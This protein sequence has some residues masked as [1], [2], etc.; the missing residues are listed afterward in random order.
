MLKKTGFTHKILNARTIQDIG[1]LSK[2]ETPN[3]VPTA[4]DSQV[5]TNEE[6]EASFREISLNTSETKI[7]D[8]KGNK[9]LTKDEIVEAAEKAAFEA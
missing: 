9:K 1:E 3:S 8:K 5:I 4:T 2:T 6:I 7:S